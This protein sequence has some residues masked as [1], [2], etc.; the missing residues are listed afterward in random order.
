M[1]TALALLQEENAGLRAQLAER[2]A[3]LAVAAAQ[4]EALSFNL[5]VL[6]RRQFGQSSEKLTAEIEQLELRLEDLEE[7]R[8]EQGAKDPLAKPEQA[9]PTKSRKPALRKP[10]PPH[11]PR[12]TVV[13]EPEIVCICQPCDRSK[14]TRL[15]EDVTEVLEKI[16]ARLKVIRHIRPR[17]ACRQCEGVFQAPAPDLPIARSVHRAWPAWPWPD[18]QCGGQQIL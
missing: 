8:A 15:G 6:K 14:L 2:D 18:R 13:H 11:L 1:D 7:S 3:A 9:A 17:Y 16:P 5:A 4:I 10:L 12:E